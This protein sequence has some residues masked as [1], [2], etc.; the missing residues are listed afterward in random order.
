MNYLGPLFVPLLLISFAA[1]SVSG[2]GTTFPAKVSVCAPQKSSA[3]GNLIVLSCQKQTLSS[4]TS[5]AFGQAYWSLFGNASFT[6][7]ADK[8]QLQLTRSAHEQE[9]G[10]YLISPVSKSLLSSFAIHYSFIIDQPL[11][12]F[13]NGEPIDDPQHSGADGIAFLIRQSS[14]SNLPSGKPDMVY[15]RPRP[16]SSEKSFHINADTWSNNVGVEDDTGDPPN[17]YLGVFLNREFNYTKKKCSYE[18][19]TAYSLRDFRKWTVWAFFDTGKISIN[20]SNVVPSGAADVGALAGEKQMTI[21]FTCTDVNIPTLFSSSDSVYLGFTSQ[22][23]WRGNRHRVLSFEM[24]HCGGANAVLSQDGTCSCTSGSFDGTSCSGTSDGGSST[25]GLSTGAIAGIAVGAVAALVL[26]GGAIYYFTRKRKPTP[27]SSMSASVSKAPL[28]DPLA[29][30]EVKVTAD[31]V[32][33]KMTTMT[34]VSTARTEIPFNEPSPIYNEVANSTQQASGAGDFYDPST[35]KSPVPGYAAAAGIAAAGVAA[36]AAV[37]A[38]PTTGG[39]TGQYVCVRTFVPTN[40]D[41]IVLNE[42]NLVAVEEIYADG[43]V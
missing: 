21:S 27:E 25:G 28:T 36:A 2:A 41:E 26:V 29:P 12:T 6:E 10:S 4:G 33:A 16:V 3:L 18:F 31:S 20:A 34:S 17:N 14:P 7:G 42:G 11:T 8:G 43:W 38:S 35:P 19:P 13:P 15:D 22:T 39:Q 32:P 24:L 40:D 37:P 23:G 9:G 1:G 30:T 5:Q